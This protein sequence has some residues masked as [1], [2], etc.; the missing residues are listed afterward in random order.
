MLFNSVEFR[1]PC[2]SCPVELVM[3]FISQ[4]K[5]PLNT[6]AQVKSGS[7]KFSCEKNGDAGFRMNSGKQ[8][9]EQSIIKK[10]KT[11]ASVLFFDRSYFQGLQLSVD[12]IVFSDFTKT[13]DVVL[14]Y[15][16][17]EHRVVIRQVAITA[18]S[19]VQCVVCVKLATY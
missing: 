9:D 1:W 12:I 13:R 10:S 8:P 5:Y 11:L 19:F 16:S 3:D 17:T 4:S 14:D 2:D 15:T 18:R 6:R 7:G